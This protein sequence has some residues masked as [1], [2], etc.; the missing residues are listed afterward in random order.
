MHKGAR[1]RVFRAKP[2][3]IL[4]LP[5]SLI[6]VSLTESSPGRRSW[7]EGTESRV[8]LRTRAA[9]S[10]TWAGA[11]SRQIAPFL[12]PVPVGPGAISAHGTLSPLSIPRRP[13][14]L[15]GSPGCH[16]CPRHQGGGAVDSEGS[17]GRCVRREHTGH[18]VLSRSPGRAVCAEPSKEGSTGGRR[19]QRKAPPQAQSWGRGG[20]GCARWEPGLRPEESAAGKVVGSE[21]AG[22]NLVHLSPIR[23]PRVGGTGQDEPGSRLRPAQISRSLL[24]WSRARSEARGAGGSPAVPGAGSPAE[25]HRRLPGLQRAEV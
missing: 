24:R 21:A 15:G 17:W 4:T 12:R 16:H 7:R 6:Q 9:K 2:P 19:A 5:S 10:S 20:C 8:P 3:T 22:G 13:G 18:G 23:A 14:S 11:S 25:P 1:K